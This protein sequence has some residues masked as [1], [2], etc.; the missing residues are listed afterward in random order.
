MKPTSS[1]LIGTVVHFLVLGSR[2]GAKPLVRYDG[3]R[4]SGRAWEDF[5][6]RHEGA[7]RSA[8]L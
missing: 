4:R 2:P 5:E 7:S 6:A 8:A 1:M 3:D